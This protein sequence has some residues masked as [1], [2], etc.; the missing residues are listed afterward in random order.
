[1][2]KQDWVWMPHAGHF[3]CGDKCRFHLN[4]RVGEFIVSTVGEYWPDAP[5]REILADSRRI[6]L[7]GRGDAREADYMRKIGYED[8][9]LGRKYET[10]VFKAKESSHKCC[11]FTMDTPTDLD[12]AGY[13]D[14]GEAYAGHLEMCEKWDNKC[15]ATQPLP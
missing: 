1:M 13:N 3:I 10:M 14:P 4:T 15:Q 2:S 8:L 7:E 5:T 11:P 12:M 6:R 9:G